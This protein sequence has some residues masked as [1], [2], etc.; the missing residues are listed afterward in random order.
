M[1]RKWNKITRNG[2]NLIDL[3]LQV[4]ETKLCQ[5]PPPQRTWSASGDHEKCL[6]LPPPLPT[7]S[8]RHTEITKKFFLLLPPPPP[9]NAVGIRR[10]RKIY[11]VNTSAGCPHPHKNPG[12]A[13]DCSKDNVVV[14][15]ARKDILCLNDDMTDKS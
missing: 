14:R 2:G 4:P 13:V 1:N 8:G 5:Y 6:L 11:R 9:P 7:K 12:Y 15:F 10:S 3:D